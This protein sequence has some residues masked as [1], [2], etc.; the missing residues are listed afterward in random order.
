M[1]CSEEFKLKKNEFVLENTS[2]SIPI[3]SEE[4]K[5]KKNEF[6]LENT[7]RSI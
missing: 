5:L 3:C 7:S 4:F 6:V 1:I 2:R